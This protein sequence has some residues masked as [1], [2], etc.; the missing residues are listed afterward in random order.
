MDRINK[1]LRMIHILLWCISFFRSHK[2]PHRRRS[3][4]AHQACAI[5]A[6]QISLGQSEQN[7]A[8]SHHLQTQDYCYP[9]LQNTPADSSVSD[10]SKRSKKEAESAVSLSMR[11]LEAPRNCIEYVV[12]HELCH[13]IHPY[14]A[15]QFYS[16]A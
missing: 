3:S 6:A 14:H 9:N 10:G 16:S 11:Y 5:A 15:K 12:I 8:Q 1:R 13:L 4:P 7:T 2:R